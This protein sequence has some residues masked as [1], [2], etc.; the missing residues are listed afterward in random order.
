MSGY[1]N[2]MKGVMFKNV[3]RKSETDRHYNGTCEIEGKEYWVSGWINIAGPR[4]KNPGSKFLSLAFTPMDSIQ[5]RV[6]PDEELEFDDD[7]PF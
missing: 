1:D 3:K 4:A 2:N 7:I 6:A 5:Q